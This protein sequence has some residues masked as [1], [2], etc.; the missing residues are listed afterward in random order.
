MVFALGV[1]SRLPRQ[2]KH[3]PVHRRQAVHLPACALVECLIGTRHAWTVLAGQHQRH[4]WRGTLLQTAVVMFPLC[5]IQLGHFHIVKRHDTINSPRVPNH[6]QMNVEP[7]RCAPVS[8]GSSGS[9]RGLISFLLVPII[10]VELI[11]VIVV[12]PSTEMVNSPVVDNRGSAPLTC[13]TESA[14]T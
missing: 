3:L 12:F 2:F 7:A 6:S 10:R 9:Q 1:D 4:L 11:V 8:A 14:A 5:R 13:R